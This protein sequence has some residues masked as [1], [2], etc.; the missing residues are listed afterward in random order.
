LRDK[1][2]AAVIEA[3]EFLGQLSIRIEPSR[4]VE[5]CDT[6]KQDPETPFNYL[7]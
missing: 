3:S 1:F 6:L 5:I 7:V 4:V 2:D